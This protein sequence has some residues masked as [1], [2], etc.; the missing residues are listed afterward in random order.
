MK[1]ERKKAELDLQRLFGTTKAKP[2]HKTV[3]FKV[4]AVRSWVAVVG[5][6]R[7]GRRGL[8]EPAA[9]D[10]PASDLGNIPF[11]SNYGVCFGMKRTAIGMLCSL[12]LGL[13]SCSRAPVMLVS[14]DR[15]PDSAA[16]RADFCYA[17]RCERHARSVDARR[18]A[19]P[20]S[21]AA[22]CSADFACAGTPTQLRG[23]TVRQRGGVCKLD[24]GGCILDWEGV[25]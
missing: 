23:Q 10:P 19:N 11:V 15:V 6:R 7:G 18:S 2:I 14:I 3:W 22:R 1:K 9:P 4:L 12:A 16:S 17:D 20:Q 8:R 5:R 25:A 13:L 24:A 21:S